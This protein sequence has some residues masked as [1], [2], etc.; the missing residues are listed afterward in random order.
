MILGLSKP[1]AAQPE[2]QAKAP[3]KSQAA[4]NT[5]SPG[6]SA[7]AADVTAPKQPVRPRDLRQT[8]LAQ[9]FAQVVAVLMRDPNFKKL[10]LAD[11]EWLVLPPLMSGQFRLAH[12]Q[13]PQAGNDKQ[14]GMLAPVAVVLWAS[15]SPALDKKLSENLEEAV[16]LQPNEW[17]S[18]DKLWL[19]A[20]A[21]DPRAIPA[22]VQQ[23]EKTEF[24]DKQVKLRRRGADGKVTIA[25]LGAN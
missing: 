16:R 7:P 11:L 12:L 25:V 5:P 24:K 18:G 1:K 9:T 15:V 14:P 20:A 4:P 13:T 6:A 22:F 2:A 23:L 8:R 17:A 10:P 19:M 3:E 21:G